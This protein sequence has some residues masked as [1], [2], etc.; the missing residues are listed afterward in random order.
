V[1]FKNGVGLFNERKRMAVNCS[2]VVAES[3]F[4]HIPSSDE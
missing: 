3:G 2:G 4:G 1:F